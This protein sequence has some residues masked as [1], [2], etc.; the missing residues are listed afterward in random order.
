[1]SSAMIDADTKSPRAAIDQAAEEIV[2]RGYSI[3][4][5]RAAHGLLCVCAIKGE[6]AVTSLDTS[7]VD[8]GIKYLKQAITG[9]YRQEKVL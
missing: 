2:A 5:D 4:I 7:S 8:A 9:N 6:V 3:R 1:M